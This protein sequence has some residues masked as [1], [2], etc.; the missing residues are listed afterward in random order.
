MSQKNYTKVLF[1]SEVNNTIM[2]LDKTKILSRLYPQINFQFIFNN[3]L[4]VEFFFFKFKDRI[5][6]PLQSCVVYKFSCGQCTSTYIGE[7]YPHLPTRI[8]EYKGMS[9][10]TGQTFKQVTISI[11]IVSKLSISQN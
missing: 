6:Y 8:A 5:P 7:T 9:V 4:S 3:Q 10:R 2:R 11:Q 1:I